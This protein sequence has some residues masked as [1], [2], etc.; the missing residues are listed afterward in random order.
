MTLDE[1]SAHFGRIAHEM[2]ATASQVVEDAI[3]DT[4]VAAE[5]LSSGVYTTADLRELGHPYA[6]RDPRPPQ[7]AAI[8]NRQTGRFQRSWKPKRLSAF[9]AQVINDSPEAEFL[10]KKEGTARM[11]ARPLVERV[12]EQV[13]PIYER[14]AA[15][16]LKALFEE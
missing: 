7:D 1:L 10:A 6:K 2:E 4:L 3:K 11:I 8:I 5:M 9:H 13:K 12:E 16:A 14:R 15:A